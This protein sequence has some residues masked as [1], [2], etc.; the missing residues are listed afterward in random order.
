M[1]ELLFRSPSPPLKTL[2]KRGQVIFLG[3]FSKQLFPGLRLGWVAAPSRITEKLTRL[4]QTS[5]LHSNLLVQGAL[6]E[7]WL[8]G[9]FLR[10]ARKSRKAYAARL[11]R[12]LECLK[13]YFPSEIEWI[14]PDG[15]FSIWLKLPGEID[16]VDFFLK[17]LDHGVVCCPGIL[18]YGDGSGRHRI[19]LSFSHPSGDELEKGIKILGEIAKKTILQKGERKESH[20]YNF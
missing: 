10:H 4:R 17:G 1:G 8:Q 20:L 18:F 19:R 3:S 2:D 14:E 6:A 11:M 9:H 13:E 12:A 15:G 5:D 7:F 16:G